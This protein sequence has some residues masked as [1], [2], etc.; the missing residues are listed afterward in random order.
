[1]SYDLFDPVSGELLEAEV[2]GR[3]PLASRQGQGQNSG[4]GTPG[5]R[6]RSGIRRLLLLQRVARAFS[7]IAAGSSAEINPPHSDPSLRQRASDEDSSR[8]SQQDSSTA[9]SNSQS[10]GEEPRS[11]RGSQET[12]D[13]GP[14]CGSGQ[15]CQSSVSD[16]NDTEM[17]DSEQMEQTLP[18]TPTDVSTS[19]SQSSGGMPVMH[20]QAQHCLQ[21]G[22]C[23]TLEKLKMPYGMM[24]PIGF[25]S[26]A[27]YTQGTM[28]SSAIGRP[29]AYGSYGML[30]QQHGG[31][32]WQLPTAQAMS[33]HVLYPAVHGNGQPAWGHLCTSNMRYPNW[34]IPIA[35]SP[36]QNA[37]NLG[38]L[39]QP[40]HS[41][42]GCQS[43]Y[44]TGAHPARVER[45]QPSTP[46]PQVQLNISSPQLKRSASE[47][48]LGKKAAPL[49]SR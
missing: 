33:G 15:E 3:R 34:S 36:A 8:R 32:A 4:R 19:V 31:A 28:P 25:R 42:A 29:S 1:M 27:A 20:P 6:I 48:S 47:G 41:D 23:Q 35:V 7:T 26:T 9:C 2:D 11:L 5:E 44:S 10:S 40:G 18:S 12:S 13:S 14:S 21:T 49:R 46:Q 17:D 38:A 37:R 43:D 30:A 45:R 16:E 39:Q 24:Q 22:S